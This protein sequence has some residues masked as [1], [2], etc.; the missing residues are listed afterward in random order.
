LSAEAL[1]EGGS[2]ENHFTP[3]SDKQNQKLLPKKSD[4]Y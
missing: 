2:I 3:K 4:F 1:G